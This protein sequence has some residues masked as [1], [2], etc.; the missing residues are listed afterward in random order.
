MN[1]KVAYL[2][3]V[4]SDYRLGVPGSWTDRMKGITQVRQLHNAT[5]RMLISF[6]GYSKNKYFFSIM[7]K[8][9][10]NRIYLIKYYMQYSFKKIKVL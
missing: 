10:K 4:M 8:I 6:N 2:N 7:Q 1:G 5:E 3:D 9:L